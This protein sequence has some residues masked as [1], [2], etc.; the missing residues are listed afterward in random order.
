MVTRIAILSSVALIAFACTSS[1]QSRPNAYEESAS[2]I[3]GYYNQGRQALD[4]Y[5]S[6]QEC[7]GSDAET[8]ETDLEEIGKS[9]QTFRISTHLNNSPGALHYRPYAVGATNRHTSLAFDYADQAIKKGC[10][11]QAD[12]VCRGLLEAYS[13]PEDASI[14]DR[15]KVC[16]DDVRSARRSTQG[17]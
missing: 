6:L 17:G 16:I 8:I 1:Q 4:R 5:K 2:E 12:Q 11:D 13:Y 10:L 9:A 14:R 3:D 15:A 7:N